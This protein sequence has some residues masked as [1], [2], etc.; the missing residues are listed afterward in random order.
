MD[1]VMC[2]IGQASGFQILRRASY[3]PR[4][5]IAGE[6]ELL[7]DNKGFRKSFKKSY[8]KNEL[9]FKIINIIMDYL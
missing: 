9:N 5:R 2:I 7:K 1:G 4:T 6:A 3:A 8:A